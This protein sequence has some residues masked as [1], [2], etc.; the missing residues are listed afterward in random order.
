MKRAKFWMIALL[1]ITLTVGFT[2]CD[3][4]DDD[5]LSGTSWSNT[6]T[7]DGTTVMTL[8]FKSN[9]KGTIVTEYYWTYGGTEEKETDSESFTYTYKAP[10]VTLTLTYDDGETATATGTVNGNKMTFIEN[11]DDTIVFTKIK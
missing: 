5:E 10:K 4:D 6:T 3:K 9:G 2:G 8:N 7:D 1:A 11:D